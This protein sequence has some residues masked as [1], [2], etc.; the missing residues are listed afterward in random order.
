MILNQKKINRTRF[1]LALDI[2]SNNNSKNIKYN[3]SNDNFDSY[4]KF[5]EDK[6]SIISIKNETE[7]P[8]GNEKN[9]S[10]EMFVRCGKNIFSLSKTNSP[11]KKEKNNYIVT[12]KNSKSFP[13]NIPGYTPDD[14]Y[15]IYIYKNDINTME[16]SNRS[17]PMQKRENKEKDS[18]NKN[19]SNKSSIS[20]KRSFSKKK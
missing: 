19:K 10:N 16:M 9:S 7:V 17:H 20:G 11:N 2:N 6:S 3:N 18:L 15:L 1:R 14:P 13:I 4:S 5:R 12:L 8:K